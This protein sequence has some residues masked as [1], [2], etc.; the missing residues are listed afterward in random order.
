MAVF[1]LRDL[2]I[3]DST[4]KL[5]QTGDDSIGVS[6]H[7]YN[8]YW[9]ERFVQV[10]RD[11]LGMVVDCHVKC[12]AEVDYIGCK[13][14]PAIYNGVVV[15]APIPMRFLKMGCFHSLDVRE[16]HLPIV[17]ASF[18]FW[19]IITRCDPIAHAWAKFVL[20]RLP[21]STPS[22]G[23]FKNLP[24]SFTLIGKTNPLID[25][26]SPEVMEFYKSLTPL[27]EAYDFCC[28]RYGVSRSDINHF[29]DYLSSIPIYDLACSVDHLVLRAVIAKEHAI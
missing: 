8:T 7:C 9:V 12:I 18:E 4:W 14:I 21:K 16:K 19:E 23:F 20:S 6:R 10:M 17:R 22:S 25:W 5:F 28:K 3:W 26:K 1:V 24:P 29:E 13:M 2:Q 11:D 15:Y 27:P